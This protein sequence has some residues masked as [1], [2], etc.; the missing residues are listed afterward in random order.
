MTAKKSQRNIKPTHSKKPNSKTPPSKNRKQQKPRRTKKQ[1]II[2]GV[3]IAVLILLAGGLGVM[4]Y[5]IFQDPEIFKAESADFPDPVYSVLTGEEISDASLNNNPT[6]CVQIPNGAD[7]ARPQAGLNQAG[8]VFEAIAERGITR[9]AAIF[10]NP[11]VGVI[12]PIRSLRP[13]YLDWDTPF[14]CTIVHA[15]GSD[16]AIAAI[17]AGGQRN[18]DE[19]LEYMWREYGGN[20]AWNNLFTSPAELAQFNSD[21]GYSTSNVKAFARLTPDEASEIVREHQTCPETTTD[22]D[23]CEISYVSPSINFGT[24]PSYNTTYTYDP[25]TNTYARFYATGEPHVVYDC[26]AE[27]SEPNTESE[28]GE[29][30][31]LAPSVVIAM[32]VSEGQMS[33]GYHEDIDTIGSGNVLIFQNGEVIEGTWQKSSQSSQIVFKDNA[34]AEIKLAPGQTWISAI[35]QYGSVTY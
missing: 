6:Y 14:D 27:S 16:E 1:K 23:S 34:G 24:M 11:T 13:Y 30:I 15:G 19:S 8:I 29:A 28:C 7:G 10:Q 31:Q 18:L 9:F 32:I 4:T 3:I 26:P 21:H 22:S 33:D 2:L 17:N 25:E 20:R 35:P 12:G 5:F